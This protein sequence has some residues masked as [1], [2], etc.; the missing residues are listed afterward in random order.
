MRALCEG[1]SGPDVTAWQNFLTGQGLFSDEVTGNFE[2]STAAATRAYQ[3]AHG[4]GSDGVIGPKSMAQALTDGFAIPDATPVP[5][6]PDDQSSPNWPAKPADIAPLEFQERAALFGTFAYKPAPTATN[7]EA[8]QITDN[9]PAQ[10]ISTFV[11]PQLA[12][13]P[14]TGG[15]KV[16]FHTK[17]GAQLV[18]LFQ[19]WEDA[20]LMPLVLSWAG[21]WAPRFVRGSR[22]N[23]SNHAWGTA[24][25][26]NAPQN[27]LGAQGPLAG[28]KGSTREL[29]TLALQHGFYNGRWFS[30]CDPMHFEVYGIE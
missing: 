13:M 16:P 1:M 11:V 22:T 5:S 10:N 7:P 19:A 18:A 29:C 23:L 4:L 20:G 15:G 8:I 3:Q 6:D 25:D 9:W 21:S 2:A 27:P 12:H 28:Q 14:G 30:R 26:I 17:A 24:F